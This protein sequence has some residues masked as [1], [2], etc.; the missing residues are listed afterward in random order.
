MESGTRTCWNLIRVVVFV[1]LG[2]LLAE[3]LLRAIFPWDRLT[4]QE[5]PFLVDMMKL[6]SHLP[7]L[8]TPKDCNS[9][10]YSQGLEY[11]TFAL[12]K[13]FGL[14]LDIRF[15]RIISALLGVLAAVF[16]AL[17][18]VRLLRAEIQ[19]GLKRLFA[20]TTWGVLWLVLSENFE[21]D[22]PHPDM[23]HMLHAAMVFC[24]CFAALETRRFPL[25]AITMIVGGLGVFSKQTEALSWVGAGLAFAIFNVWGWRR[26]LLLFAIG[27]AVL[28]VSLYI[29]WLPQYGRFFTFALPSQEKLDLSKL[30]ELA[31]FMLSLW[32]MTLLVLAVIAG[33]C[34]WNWRGVGRRYL[35]CWGLVGCFTVAPNLIAFLKPLGLSN[36]LVAFHFWMTLMVWPFIAI[37]LNKDRKESAPPAGTN[38]VDD[39]RG[40]TIPAAVI[41][42]FLITLLM[43]APLK[44]VPHKSDYAFC[45][46]VQS[47]V[48]NDVQAGHKILVSYGAAFY[49]RA[50]VTTPPLDQGCTVIE[51]VM[52]GRD[53]LLA[54]FKAKIDTHYYDKIYLMLDGCYGPKMNEEINQY[55]QV[56]SV[57]PCPSKLLSYA[58]TDCKV[59]VPR[60]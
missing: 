50:G 35:A 9:M 26:S 5:A 27:G 37:L 45:R 4:W 32:R 59:L 24:L 13:P 57:I 28:C 7:V 29:L 34:L 2:L 46:Q 40:R 22:M 51:Y 31:K 43:E 53:D 44:P 16:G 12:L 58:M 25:A 6:N 3:I 36:N 17:T 42:I 33:L 8:T 39:W 49:T 11:L 47:A 18:I 20:F 19:G 14:A 1:Y 41:L 21:S 54:D 10:I 56:Q 60:N 52:A 38:F 15:Y 55:Y 23:L 30:K 48:Q